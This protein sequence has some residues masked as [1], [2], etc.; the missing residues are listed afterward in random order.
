MLKNKKLIMRHFVLFLYFYLEYNIPDF[1]STEEV[2]QLAKIHNFRIQFHT[3]IA[4]LPIR[5][6]TFLET[7]LYL[8]EGN[9]ID[10]DLASDLVFCFSYFLFSRNINSIYLLFFS[11]FSL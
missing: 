4:A 5:C 10:I 6:K 3:K 9:K 7:W 11:L 1:L 2:Y 8:S